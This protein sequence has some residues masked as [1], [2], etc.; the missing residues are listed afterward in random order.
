MPD[1]DIFSRYAAPGWHAP[2]KCFYVSADPDE[3]AR[4]TLRS[5]G[6]SLRTGG[7]LAPLSEFADILCDHSNH[8]LT[9]QRALERVRAV[10]SAH[11]HDRHVRVAGATVSRIIAEL[12]TGS[13]LIVD[14]RKEVAIMDGGVAFFKRKPRAWR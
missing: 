6:K 13:A 3:I 14:P 11:F 12:A 10:V 2:M 9:T 1:R 4:A 7:G 8:C 5:L